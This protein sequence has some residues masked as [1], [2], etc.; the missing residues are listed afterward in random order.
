MR[1][2]QFHIN[3]VNKK[4]SV[5][6]FSCFSEMNWLPTWMLIV[7]TISFTDTEDPVSSILASVMET[8]ITDNLNHGVV[9]SSKGEITNVNGKSLYVAF[10][11]E[12]P[13]CP[14]FTKLMVNHECKHNEHD[15]ENHDFNYEL[16]Q[17][18]SP[19]MDLL[20]K[21][22]LLDSDQ[23][24]K[25]MLDVSTFFIGGAVD[26]SP[27]IFTRRKRNI[28]TEALSSLSGLASKR[29]LQR[30]A[31]QFNRCLDS[32]YTKFKT[33]TAEFKGMTAALKIEHQNINQVSSALVLTQE[34]LNTTV[35]N[36]QKVTF[37]FSK[38]NAL[39]NYNSQKIRYT[40]HI[41]AGIMASAQS[42]SDKMSEFKNHLTDFLQG[43]NLLVSGRLSTWLVPP[44]LLNQ[45]LNNASNHLM[46]TDPIFTLAHPEVKFY[47]TD[48]KIAHFSYKECLVI[49]LQ[50]PL[51]RTN[52]QKFKIFQTQV[53]PVPVENTHNSTSTFGYTKVLNVP[54]YFAINTA[55]QIIQIDSLTY[56]SCREV[57]QRQYICPGRLLVE[58]TTA[59]PCVKGIFL[60][61][62]NKI[63]K[64]C[65]I[66]YLGKDYKPERKILKGSNHSLVLSG[67]PSS[68]RLKLLCDSFR[69]DIVQHSFLTRIFLKCG[70]CLIGS[71]FY[72][73]QDTSSCLD[74][75]FMT[76][77]I[78]VRY[79]INMHIS[80]TTLFSVDNLEPVKPRMLNFSL[81]SKLLKYHNIELSD[82][83]LELTLN[84]LESDVASK[85][86]KKINF[87][88]GD[89]DMLNILI[90]CGIALA[91]LAILTVIVIN[92]RRC[93]ISHQAQIPAAQ[94]IKPAAQVAGA[95]M[96]AAQIQQAEALVPDTQTPECNVTDIIHLPLLAV[97]MILI[98]A[99]IFLLYKVFKQLFRYFDFAQAIMSLHRS[100]PPTLK[101]WLTEHIFLILRSSNESARIYLCTLKLFPFE[102]IHIS[103]R[104]YLQKYTF[105]PGCLIG[106]MSLTS[107]P[108]KFVDN[109]LTFKLPDS[110]PIPFL[111]QRKVSRLTKNPHTRY[112]AAGHRGWY[113]MIDQ[114]TSQNDI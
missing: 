84:Q 100:N 83:T 60:R 94:N 65:Q 42:I 53:V 18:F 79:P 67:F 25:L 31:S 63:K 23:I 37:T 66:T 78:I 91:G 6:Q 21:Q 68:L 77:P 107:I 9:F 17:I 95:A 80:N 8:E 74:K 14:D 40:A 4:P 85:N 5:I 32:V 72:L 44:T 15:P 96:M 55:H 76:Q 28:I 41:T 10:M 54:S 1:F 47:Y 71:D 112:L 70:C 99:F 75:S 3:R 49:L 102:V 86:F 29:Q 97:Y 104:Q 87:K 111:L 105:E 82:P 20:N 92:L 38:V 30:L 59:W 109:D 69:H 22:I 114:P 34:N 12:K 101:P 11:V 43:L 58:E 90:Y 93:Y 56:T 48:S 113:R 81:T 98:L 106:K 110:V 16:C 62:P 36:L 46:A 51:V 108:L 24:N 64:N 73:T 50:V 45:T 27:E 103:D 88:F 33:Q 26:V 13:E 52:T 2:F 7:I 19:V 35:E 57:L 39:A 89:N 61:N